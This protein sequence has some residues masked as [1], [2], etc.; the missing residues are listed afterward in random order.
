[1]I[2]QLRDIIKNYGIPRRSEILYTSVEDEYIE[3]EEVSDYPVRLF[4]TREGY[5]KKITPQSYRMSGDHKLKE[6]DEI[7]MEIE[8]QNNAHLL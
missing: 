2:A 1:I 3:E 8:S 4:F 6:T 7:T 5:F